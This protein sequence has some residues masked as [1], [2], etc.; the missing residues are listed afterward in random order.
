M[1]GVKDVRPPLRPPGDSSQ[2]HGLLAWAQV[3]EGGWAESLGMMISNP[4]FRKARLW[5]EQGG[6][7]GPPPRPR[8]ETTKS[9]DLSCR[10]EAG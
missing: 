3:P 10:D 6:G 5:G 8:W 9:L 7:K 1:E 4:C 2:P